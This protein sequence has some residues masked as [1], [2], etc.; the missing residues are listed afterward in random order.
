MVDSGM[1][2][3]QVV[4]NNMIVC[5]FACLYYC[6]LVS[7]NAWK[8]ESVIGKEKRGEQLIGGSRLK[9][10]EVGMKLRN[11]E[12]RQKAVV[13]CETKAVRNIERYIKRMR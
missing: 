11:N 7:L 8:K 4:A 13:F 2:E 5:L 12:R 1:N 10:T 3:W 9:A 6:L